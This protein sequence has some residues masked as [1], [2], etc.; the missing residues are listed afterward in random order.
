MPFVRRIQPVQI[1]SLMRSR[2]QIPSSP[3]HSYERS[4]SQ[5]THFP[6]G[7][8]METPPLNPDATTDPNGR[9]P[10]M[11]L[12]FY[13][14]SQSHLG[15]GRGSTTTNS[16]LSLVSLLVTCPRHLVHACIGAAPPSI[17]SNADTFVSNITLAQRSRSK[18]PLTLDTEIEPA[19]S[20]PLL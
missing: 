17:K 7:R 10:P 15:A 20:P 11:G 9:F 4:S 5:T 19:D 8:G 14:P 6:S 18:V 2:D 1:L 12:P 13:R 16:S 3:A